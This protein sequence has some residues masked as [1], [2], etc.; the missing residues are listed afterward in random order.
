[1]VILAFCDIGSVLSKLNPERYARL[2]SVP[3][4]M[5]PGAI[6]ACAAVKIWA[7]DERTCRLKEIEMGG[8]GKLD[9]SMCLFVRKSK[10]KS[11]RLEVPIT[12]MFPRSDR[13][14]AEHWPTISRAVTGRPA[15]NDMTYTRRER[16]DPTATKRP[17]LLP[18]RNVGQYRAVKACRPFTCC[19]PVVSFVIRHLTFVVVSGFPNGIKEIKDA[20]R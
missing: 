9:I 4:K 7:L 6:K 10:I 15:V 14:N 19:I 8:D 18:E 2:G 5:T 13:D 12:R 20:A 11:L 1:M 17:Q 3:A 16:C